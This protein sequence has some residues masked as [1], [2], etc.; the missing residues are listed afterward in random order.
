MLV[1]LSKI[2]PPARAQRYAVGG[3][4]ITSLESAQ[5]IVAAAESCKSPVILQISEKTVDY[6][7]LEVAYAIASTCAE[8][9]TVPIAVHFDHGRNIELLKKSIQIG[10]TSAMIDVSKLPRDEKIRQTK[11]FVDFANKYRVTVEAEEDSIGGSEDYI[12]GERWT[13]TDPA[14][15]AAFVA[16]TKIDAYAVSIGSSHGAPL[17]DEKLDLDLLSEISHKVK[18]PLVLHGASSTENSVIREV[19]ARGIAKINIDTDL[20]VAF[21]TQLRQTLEQDKQV[22]DPRDVLLPSRE[23]VMDVVAEKIKLFGSENKA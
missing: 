10:F 6:M 20:R 19:I 23:A 11:T 21:T 12:S 1:N 18:I 14:R 4:N 22:I 3:F 5:A 15:A 7:G 16:A 2:L 8:N 17:P 13:F 9:S